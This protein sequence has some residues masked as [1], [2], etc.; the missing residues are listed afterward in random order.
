MKRLSDYLGRIAFGFFAVVAMTGTALA[1]DPLPIPAPEPATLAILAGG[2]A[3]AIYLRH[4][5]RR[6]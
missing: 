3:T 4:R 5:N 1:G 6:K 2:V